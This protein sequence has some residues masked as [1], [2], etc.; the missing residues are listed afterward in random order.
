MRKGGARN[1]WCPA[2]ARGSF[3]LFSFGLLVSYPYAEVLRR[4][5]VQNPGG[6]SNGM[7]QHIHVTAVGTMPLALSPIALW[8]SIMFRGPKASLCGRAAHFAAGFYHGLNFRRLL[9]T[10]EED[11]EESPAEGFSS[12]ES[13]LYWAFVI[14]IWHIM[15]LRLLKRK[16]EE[17]E[18]GR[19]R[20]GRN[21]NRQD[22]PCR[23]VVFDRV[24]YDDDETGR[25][26]DELDDLETPL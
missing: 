25:A 6:D 7:F 18:V 20:K 13:V 12:A 1:S 14:S 15:W 16:G 24:F 11:E 26:V 10:E 9:F 21:I 5:V 23:T 19:G 2:V 17:E 4:A 22:R 3:L 8:H